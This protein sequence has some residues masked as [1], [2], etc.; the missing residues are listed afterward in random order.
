MRK[1][2]RFLA[3]TLAVTALGACLNPIGFN[4][5]LELDINAKIEGD[6][7]VISPDATL[8]IQNH[9]TTTDI[10]L[11]EIRDPDLLSL[12]GRVE[13]KPKAGFEKLFNL[14]PRTTVDYQIKI[15]FNSVNPPVN[16]AFKAARPTWQWEGELTGE[17]SLP[18]KGLYY[19]HFGRDKNGQLFFSLNSN[20]YN[21]NRDGTDHQ[22]TRTDPDLDQ[23]GSTE[24]GL[25]Q[26]T[27]K[28]YGLLVVKN[29][30]TVPIDL[31][32]F[33]HYADPGQINNLEDSQKLYSMSPG[34]NAKTQRSILLGPNDWHMWSSFTV[35]GRTY[36]FP[37]LPDTRVATVT[38]GKV[39]YVYFY[40]TKTGYGITTQWPP[41]PNDAADDNTNPNDILNPNDGILRIINDS[42][43]FIEEI[44]WDGVEIPLPSPI[45][46]GRNAGSVILS[47]GTKSLAFR[48]TGSPDFGRE[49][50]YT[51]YAQKINEIIYTDDFETD[52]PPVGGGLIR[53]FNNATDSYTTVQTIKI[54]NLNDASAQRT[55]SFGDFDPPGIIGPNGGFGKVKLTNS[56]EL[57]IT[58]NAQYNID[59]IVSTTEGSFVIRQ[60]DQLYNRTVIF[61]IDDQKIE[62][63]KQNAY[64]YVDMANNSD[65]DIV[66]IDIYDPVKQ[67]TL[68]V[69][70]Y[71]FVKGQ[72][73]A[74]GEK[75]RFTV[76]NTAAFELASGRNYEFWAIV[77]R[78][79]GQRAIKKV[80]SHVLYRTTVYIV[81]DQADIDS[82]QPP[83]PPKNDVYT[84]VT[85]T[86]LASSVTA[87]VNQEISLTPTNFVPATATAVTKNWPVSW[88]VQSN[89]ASYDIGYFG[90]ANVHVIRP[91]STGTITVKASIAGGVTGTATT[92]GT[93][94]ES[95]I[96]TITVN[97]SQ[98]SFTPVSNISGI[99]SRVFV[100]VNTDAAASIYP[101]NAGPNGSPFNGASV[102]WS[103]MNN[104]A[105]AAIVR[106]N[107][108]QIRTG[109]PGSFTLK[110]V[111]PGGKGSLGD[112]EQT[113]TIQSELSFAPANP[114]FV[115]IRIKYNGMPVRSTEWRGNHR[116]RYFEVVMR[117]ATVYNGKAIDDKGSTYRDGSLRTGKAAVEW[118]YSSYPYANRNESLWAGN[119]QFSIRMPR[120]ATRQTGTD[121]LTNNNAYNQVWAVNSWMTPWRI[122]NITQPDGRTHDGFFEPGDG[123][124]AQPMAQP[125]DPPLEF[126]LP[127]K[128]PNDTTNRKS[129]VYW[130][131][132]GTDQ[133]QDGWGRTWQAW[134]ILQWFAIDIDAVQ[135]KIGRD[136]FIEVGLRC[137]ASGN[138]DQEM[139]FIAK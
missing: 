100:G 84:P 14:R 95:G 81:L 126:W 13:N 58:R 119:C 110:A 79:G 65:A 101:S 56:T 138:G 1:P 94:Y 123:F 51:V 90:G 133:N 15:K 31:I 104:N 35:E 116:S 80:A 89:T 21:D 6:I 2:L 107:P 105:G 78:G 53:I 86:T 93:T 117:P 70:S 102:N 55:L 98:S 135:D 134:S 122:G 44:K 46:P 61:T 22:D 10:T 127:V 108:L 136:G 87:T 7:S 128:H 88:V 54:T 120:I 59:V 5:K 40:K 27:M 129:T 43:K 66:G 72:P 34:P 24:G 11:V 4:P 118:A 12:V 20:E 132:A 130:I 109:A 85:A 30:S 139:Y 45:P 16:D 64:G 69:S 33:A 112:Y 124:L 37:V 36:N 121:S 39:S 76:Y 137:Y 29:L 19:L 73:V 106:S 115:G 111:I 17:I 32:R 62:T 68:G 83:L 52:A 97:S 131:R 49:F 103:V 47:A 8:V 60:I 23:E 74:K 9:T 50:S 26:V 28:Q 41:F 92:P 114:S 77:Q 42:R 82:L 18:K 71:Q 75:D 91:T 48:V 125:G 63:N 67:V 25:D 96:I 99:P 57:P 113:W 3:L 38:V